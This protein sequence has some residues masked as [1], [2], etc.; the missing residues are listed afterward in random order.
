MKWRNGFGLNE[1]TEWKKYNAS[2]FVLYLSL[3]FL[4][5]LSFLDNWLMTWY[6]VCDQTME[7]ME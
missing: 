6:M 7:L 3:F 5:C 2:V 4:T 1:S